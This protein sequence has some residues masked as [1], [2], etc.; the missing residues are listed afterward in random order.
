MFRQNKN[1]FKWEEKKE[2][3][4]QNKL[5]TAGLLI[6]E[7]QMILLNL[8]KTNS[9]KL[10]KKKGEL[11]ALYEGVINVIQNKN[12]NFPKYRNKIKQKGLGEG[13]EEES[14]QNERYTVNITIHT[15]TIQYKILQQEYQ[16]M[17]Q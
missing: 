2:K 9:K 14:L 5:F 4:E 7:N 15:V 16:Q 10:S 12:T 1:I 13:R 8:I 11:R 3:E 17:Y 6:G